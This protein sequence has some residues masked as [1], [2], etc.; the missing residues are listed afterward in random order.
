[1]GDKRLLSLLGYERR[2]WRDVWKQNLSFWT[3]YAKRFRD[4]GIMTVV[5]LAVMQAF[6]RAEAVEELLMQVC[7]AA[8]IGLVIIAATNLLWTCITTPARLL[9]RRS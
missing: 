4:E 3:E 2:F 1:M 6:G 9:K 7:V 8:P 5:L